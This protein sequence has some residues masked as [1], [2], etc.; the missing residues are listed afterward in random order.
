[1]KKTIIAFL[2]LSM[3]AL[4]LNAQVKIA[5][6]SIAKCHENYYLTADVNHKI[7]STIES[8]QTEAKSRQDALKAESEPLQ[9]KVSEIR[10][11][12]GLSDTAKQEQMS[13]LGPEIQAFRAKEAVFQEWA[14][15]SEQEAEASS[16]S[17]NQNLI[18]DIKRVVIAVALRDGSQL[19]LD[20]S[21]VL[22]NGLP[23]VL[24]SD[25]SI[26]ITNKVINEL[27]K[28]QPSN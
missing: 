3:L 16:T 19:V 13:E 6:V 8:L 2:A 24:Y 23:P 14:Q 12:P 1:M 10:D 25:P 28:D 4:S 9:A 18:E 21:D 26:D 20:T 15:Q 17:R 7:R 5:T 22:S 11:N 27:N